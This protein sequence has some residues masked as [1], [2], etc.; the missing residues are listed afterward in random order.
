MKKSGG[1]LQWSL[2]FNYIVLGGGT[3]NHTTTQMIA[4]RHETCTS[5]QIIVAPRLPISKIFQIF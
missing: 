2:N 5:V 1:N 3:I 4:E